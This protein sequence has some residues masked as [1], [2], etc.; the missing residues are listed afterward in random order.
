MGGASGGIETFPLSIKGFLSNLS[1]VKKGFSSFLCGFAS[2]WHKSLVS[3]KLETPFLISVPHLLKLSF[4]SLKYCSTAATLV[5]GHSCVWCKPTSLNHSKV[6]MLHFLKRQKL[7]IIS[8]PGGVLCCKNSGCP[9]CCFCFS[10]RELRA[11]RACSVVFW[12]THSAVSF[13]PVT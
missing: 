11:R 12:N 7:Y 3:L 5:K 6:E 8:P 13:S 9:C 1:K 2:L 4:N 10:C